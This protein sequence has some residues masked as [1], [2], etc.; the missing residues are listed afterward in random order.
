MRAGRRPVI[1]PGR[2]AWDLLSVDNVVHAH[3][4]AADTEHISG[5]VYNIARGRLVTARDLVD[6]LNLLLGTR[7][8]P[9]I[10][11]ASPLE[12]C[13][14]Q[15]DT[16]RAEAELGYCPPTSLE[17]GLH[18]WITYRPSYAEQMSN[19]SGDFPHE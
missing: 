18:R 1:P 15:A 7:L 13:T 11:T 19:Q 17:Q 3:L 14:V 12:D 10:G 8:T 9:V 5:R 16:H 4:L 6:R 2:R